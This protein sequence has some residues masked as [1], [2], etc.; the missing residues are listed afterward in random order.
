[1]AATR[2]YHFYIKASLMTIKIEKASLQRRVFGQ[3]QGV[4][5]VFRSLRRVRS[6]RD[7]E[8]SQKLPIAIGALK[9][10]LNQ[11][12]PDEMWL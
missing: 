6:L 9:R 5:C 4:G 7:A 11:P 1:M 3:K 12:L 10:G 8:P 2:K